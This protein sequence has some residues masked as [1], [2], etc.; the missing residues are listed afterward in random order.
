MPGRYEQAIGV[1]RIVG[2]DRAA[3][4]AGAAEAA[5]RAATGPGS[6]L[7]G[8]DRLRAED[9]PAVGVPAAG[10]GLRQRGD[11]LAAAPRLAAG[12][13]PAA[14]ARDPAAVARRRRRDRLVAGEPRL[15][16]RAGEKGGGK[17]GPNPT[18]RGKP[19]AK[20]HLVADRRGV[21]LAA[22]LSA[23]NCHD[24]KLFEALME[25]IPPIV[26]PRGKPGRPRKRPGKLHA[27]K[28]YDVPRC[29]R[30]L[31]RRGIG[32]RI[33]RR[34]VESGERLGR[35][36]WVVERTLA[37]VA[38][39]RRLAIRYERRDDIHEALLH[40]ACSLICLNFLDRTAWF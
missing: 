40:L 31:R 10:A 20:R 23:A 33:A 35:H 3:A 26:G 4:P 13:R 16:E 8:G 9:R 38:R 32:C 1:G 12:R 11:L 5:G 27:D 28:A 2:G 17:T 21:P 14:P 29:R 7:P 36:R 18:D 30:Y 22:K 34:G 39:Y 24:S 19:G 37:W 6:G 15:R 25:A